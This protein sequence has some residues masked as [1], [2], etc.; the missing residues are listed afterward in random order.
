MI[1]T[2]TM[3]PALDK[4]ANL[5]QL[6]P[7]ALNRLQAVRTDVGG[8]GVNVSKMIAA[9]GGHSVCTGFVG[10]DTGREVC[11]RLDACGIAHAFL[12]VEG[13]TR[14]NL[15]IV[16]GDGALTELNEPG[17]TVTPPE[18]AA[19][20][21]KVRQLAGTTGIVV[22]SGSLPRGAQADTY[23][24][25]AHALRRVGCRVIVDADGAALR[26]ALTVPPHAI[27]PNLL[28]LLQ[29]FG[30]PQDTPEERLPALCG[31]LLARGVSLVMLS[32]G[33]RGALFVTHDAAW[34]APACKVKVCSTVGAGDSMVGA[35]AFALERGYNLEQTARLAMACATGAVM[36][37]GTNPP[38][39]E[40]VSKYLDQIELFSL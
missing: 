6:V 2:V 32:M 17:I 16:E 28:E 21:T 26:E 37:E 29:L 18:L 14:T 35:A 38:S 20:Q 40:T 36:T 1:V 19:L 30:L 15:K 11:R 7:H 10:G 5:T 25:F 12:T 24:D 22:L 9:L 33:A 23:R 34:R 4:T 27:K 8:K 3:N 31:E 39:T 13:D